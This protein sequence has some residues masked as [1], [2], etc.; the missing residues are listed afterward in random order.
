MC[1][2]IIEFV[3]V[4]YRRGEIFLI[5][6]VHMRM[7]LHGCTVGGLRRMLGS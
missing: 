5:L 4:S 3:Y 6:V 7:R 1:M 2:I